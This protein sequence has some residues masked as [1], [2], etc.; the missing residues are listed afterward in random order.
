MNHSDLLRHVDS[1]P[2]TAHLNFC[3]DIVQGLIG[4]IISRFETRGYKLVAMRMHYPTK[5][6]AQEHYAD[7][8]NK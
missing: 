4:Q 2:H 3:M 5:A 7:L 8:S 1:Y 6:E